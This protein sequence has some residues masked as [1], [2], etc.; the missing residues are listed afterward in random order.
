MAES[1]PRELPVTV[2]DAGTRLDHFLVAQLADVSRARVQQLVDEGKITVNSKAAKPSLRLKGKETITI[3]GPVE[4]P[5]LRAFAED[6]PLDVVFEDAD[7]AVINKAAG[8]VVHASN[9]SSEDPRN[10]G[11]LVNALLHRFKK[12]SSGGG[13]LRPGIVHRLD[14]DTSGLLI[15]AKNDRTHRKLAEMFSKRTVD[16]R[17]TALV[18]GWPSKDSG[19]L[20]IP[21]GRDR[22]NR[23][24]M[25]TRGDEA[26]DAVSH[27][28]VLEKIDSRYGKFSLVEVKIDT[29]RTHQIRV[30]MASLKHPVVGDTL[31]GAPQVLSPLTR[32]RQRYGHSVS[33][34]VEAKKAELRKK[35]GAEN[36]TLELGRNF[37]HS[38][39]LRFTHPKSGEELAF[40][41]QLPEELDQLLQKL[42]KSA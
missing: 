16:K 24:R 1:Y 38:T 37:L 36:S 15:V 4:L 14:K 19:T 29:G 5:P 9:G 41:S 34:R 6:I 40:S 13:D 20:N 39:S 28:T 21:I 27:Y 11:T 8:M 12:L 42:R 25:T 3:H 31:Y 35:K 7:L 2:E 33:T 30:H 17:Y 32:D 10:R 22:S 23:A 18:H 26:R